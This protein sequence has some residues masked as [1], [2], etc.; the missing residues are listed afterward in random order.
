[1]NNIGKLIIT[2]IKNGM[3]CSFSCGFVAGL[4]PNEINVSLNETRYVNIP[5]PLITGMLGIIGFTT[6]PLLLGNYFYESAQFDNLIDKYDISIKR[7]HQYDNKN[8]KYGFPSTININCNLKSSQ[9]L[10]KYE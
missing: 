1:M 2:K 4:I 6:S 3:I 5:L 7:Y 10:K 9:L 8:D